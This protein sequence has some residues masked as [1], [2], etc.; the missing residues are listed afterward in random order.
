MEAMRTKQSILQASAD[1]ASVEGL[2]SVTIG[3][4]AERLEMSKSGVIGHFRSK[5]QLQIEI[6]ETVV[7][8]FRM[9]V[10]EPVKR[11][12]PGL[13]RLL[14]ACQAWVEYGA[15]P[16]YSGGCLLTQAT[17][18]YDGRPGPVHD[19]IAESRHAWRQSLRRDIQA[20][21]DAGDLAASLDIDVVIYG[22]E[23]LS[24][25]ITPARLLN[26]QETAGDFALRAM[27]S[28]LGL[29]GDSTSDG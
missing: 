1:M 21:V 11:F 27:W 17:Y 8:D 10:W 16:G 15:S 14:A 12:N 6:V 29:E 22:M 2:D 13:P 18:D 20:A 25:G 28:L 4:L 24:A 7:E 9:R 23:S 3:R 26:G 5:S 19:L